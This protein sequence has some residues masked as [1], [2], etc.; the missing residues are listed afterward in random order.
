MEVPDRLLCDTAQYLTSTNYSSVSS[1]ASFP[2]SRTSPELTH[3]MRNLVRPGWLQISSREGVSLRKTFRAAQNSGM[4]FSDNSRGPLVSFACVAF[5][6]FI[7]CVRAIFHG[8]GNGFVSSAIPLCLLEGKY[9]VGS[10]GNR[11]VV[12]ECNNNVLVVGKH[13]ERKYLK[14]VQ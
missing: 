13:L 8:T 6:L 14:P 7:L 9:K 1:A 11:R 5:V 4:L 12:T 2:S 3:T 10:R